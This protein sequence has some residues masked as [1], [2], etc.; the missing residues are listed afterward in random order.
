MIDDKKDL[1]GSK[2]R[3]RFKRLHKE[4]TYEGFYSLDI[5]FAFVEKN[6]N[7]G[8]KDPVIV[9]I[10]DFKM[11]SDKLV[12]SEVLAYNQFIENHIP[13][14]IVE[15]LNEDFCDLPPNKHRF[16]VKRYLG[17]DY[18]PDPPE[19]D[20]EIVA[21]NLTWDGFASW[22]SE[23]RTQRRWEQRYM[24]M[25]AEGMREEKERAFEN[26]DAERIKALDVVFEAFLEDEELREQVIEQRF[27]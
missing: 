26:G 2:N 25:I 21:D 10:T 5:D 24:N 17:G 13:V 3:D 9:A 12:F 8:R 18:K 22:Q 14:F 1:E 7:K 16:R 15:A 23:L 11:P 4:Q 19:W 20:T 6:H 27:G